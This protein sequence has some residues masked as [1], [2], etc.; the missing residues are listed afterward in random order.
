ME[1]FGTCS[2]G[3]VDDRMRRLQQQLEEM[4]IRAQE[5]ARR[6]EESDRR[7]EESDRKVDEAD[8]RAEESDRR[9]EESDTRAEESDMRA[10]ES[11]MRAEE[12]DRRTEE[13]DMRAEESDMRAEESDRRADESDMRAEESNRRA[14]ESDMRAEESDMR[15][16]ESDRRAEESD[17]RAEE[18]DMRVGQL[19]RE[20][21]VVSQSLQGKTRKVQLARQQ[22]REYEQHLQERT[23]QV[24]SAWEQLRECEQ[25]LE[26]CTWEVTSAREQLRECERRLTSSNSHW[27]VRSEEVEMTGP[28]LGRGGWAIVSVATFRGMR[29]AAKTIHRQIIS[30]HNV[31]LFRRE[32]NMAARLRHPNLVQFIGATM[33]GNMVILTE[34]MPTSL[35][36]QLQQDI[37][38]QPKIVMSVSLDVAR[39]LNYLHQMQP[40]PIIHRDI[41]SA[42]VLLEP[43]QR[44]Q[45]RAKLSDY[46]TVN[47]FHQLE[48]VNPGSPVY[49]APE[50]NDPCLQSTKMDI[51]SFGALMLEML[52]GQLPTPEDRPALLLKVHHDQLLDLIC[53]CLS[54]RAQDRPDAATFIGELTN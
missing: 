3:I 9:A 49:A 24:T 23:R 36:A 17:R 45:W 12:S 27:I 32:M 31:Q 44:L 41:S 51:Y 4:E 20:L 29:V 26:E 35:R 18:S 30:H 10:E 15:A 42:N 38:L 40:D 47:L 14:E 2:D 16:E 37:Y 13:S 53:R 46:G 34:L 8:G 5:S 28:E 54:E 22:Q 21:A 50:A 11:D 7:A 19:Q 52:T 39:A 43:I 1:S 6:A 48:T 33:E 25:H